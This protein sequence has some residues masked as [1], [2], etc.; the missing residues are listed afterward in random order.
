MEFSTLKKNLKK[1]FSSFK[2]VKIAVLGEF[3]T[4]LL[5]Q[6]L[7]GYG[8]EIQLNYD[9]Y[10]ADYSQIE[11][12]IYDP[13]SE[14]Y[15][16]E[17][18]FIL[19]FNSVQKQLVNYYKGDI[20]SK[21][22]FSTTFLNKISA[23]LD[24]IDTNSKST[25]ILSNLPE[26]N[27]NVY[28][29]YS[30]KLDFTFIYHTRKINIGLMQLAQERKNLFIND[31]ALLQS[32]YGYQNTHDPKL[33]I[34][35]DMVYNMS[36][37]PEIAK[38]TTDIILSATG[39]FKK[40]LILDLDN[41]VWGGI[42]GDDGIEN[43]Q[44][45]D[46]GIGKAFSELQLWA[47][48]LKE[49]GI[50]LAACSK[51]DEK[52]A[53][54]AFENHP[55]M[56]LQLEDFS[57]F[58]ANWENKAEN[59]KQIQ[60]ILNI[61]F[62][63]MVFIDD[64]PFE[65]DFVR[66]YIPE[67]TIPEM[68]EDPAEYLP[69]LRSLNLFETASHSEEDSLRTASYRQ[70]AERQTLQK[71]FVNEDDYLKSLS[72]TSEVKPFDKFTIPRV[73]QLTQRS[74]QFNLRTIRYSEEEITSISESKDL[75]TLSFTLKDKLGE[76]GLIS[77]IILKAEKDKSLFV[78]TWIMSCRVLKRTMENFVL[79]SIVKTGKENGFDKLIGEY[80]PTKKNEMV[81]NHYSSLGFKPNNNHWELDINRY[82]NL[83]TFIDCNP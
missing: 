22:C 5:V 9:I 4:Q 55:D 40:C 63:S 25:V 46:F 74:N 7:K 13:G 61:G 8:Y 68:P 76:Y 56:V 30:N 58:T 20:K 3:S 10:E 52:I 29:N 60:S 23:L 66:T 12:Q 34:T 14:L 67:I 24:T 73:S 47:K 35:A 33:Y 72:M 70:E 36:F 64:S 27:D 1:D 59:I 31:I 71:A 50:I 2:K 28:G 17:P 54:G 32:Y 42:I 51:N 82:Q 53:K 6:A 11:R 43:I 69:Y 18:E 39:T 15:S 49:R 57:V 75:Y 38:N 83:K 45:G 44:V 21:K 26:I 77:V 19:I 62:D 48:Q 41:T 78:D 16:F 37:L 81:R 80:I 79:N 65:R